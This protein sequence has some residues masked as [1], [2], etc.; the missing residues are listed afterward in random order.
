M[1]HLPRGNILQKSPGYM[2]KSPLTAGKA[3][4]LKRYSFK[5]APSNNG[6]EADT[7][8]A[9]SAIGLPAGRKRYHRKSDGPDNA[10]IA[11]SGSFGV[12][13]ATVI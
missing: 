11:L 13:S 8:A 4:H 6:R 10:V 12:L 2:R 5:S 3:V 7:P 9:F 1:I